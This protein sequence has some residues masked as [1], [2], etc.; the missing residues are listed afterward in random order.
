MIDLPQQK[1]IGK[2][3]SLCLPPFWNHETST[4]TK[5]DCVIT[6]CTDV[7]RDIYVTSTSFTFLEVNV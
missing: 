1:E 3:I 2:H 4:G 6:N 7:L 5:V